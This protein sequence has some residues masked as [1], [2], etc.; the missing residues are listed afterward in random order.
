MEHSFLYEKNKIAITGVKSVDSFDEKE[1]EVTLSD[2]GIVIHGS[3]FVL[4]EMAQ[5]GG[6]L[7]FSGHVSSVNYRSKQEKTT[8]LKKLF[9]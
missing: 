2:N 4:L 9:K 5:V 8:F 6:K 3:D 7:C 1:V